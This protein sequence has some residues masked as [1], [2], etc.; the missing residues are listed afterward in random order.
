[1]SVLKKRNDVK[2]SP[3]N[4]YDKYAKQNKIKKS[5]NGKNCLLVLVSSLLNDQLHTIYMF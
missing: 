1:M 2:V 3:S 4:L 5:Q